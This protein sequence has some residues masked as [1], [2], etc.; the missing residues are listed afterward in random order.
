MAAEAD[1]Q[2]VAVTQDRDVIRLVGG[3]VACDLDRSTGRIVRLVHTASEDAFV[4]P[5]TGPAG[6][7]VFDELDRK[8]YTDLQ[9]P[10]THRRDCWSMSGRSTFVKQFEGAP[11]ALRCTWR[12]S[13]DG[14]RLH[15]EAFLHEG[16]A[17][18]E[19]PHQRR[20]AGDAGTLELD[21]VVAGA[22]GRA[23]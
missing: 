8:W 7:E 12:P 22:V 13:G 21:A 18:A 15:V 5:Q 16:A 17:A 4:S 23:D 10:A 14:V 3:G 19:H 20:A 9:T 11:F 1:L 2:R 6:L